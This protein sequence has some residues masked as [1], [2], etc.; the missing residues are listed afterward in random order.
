[1]QAERTGVALDYVGLARLVLRV[2]GAVVVLGSVG[3][4]AAVG[5]YGVPNPTVI[6]AS[7]FLVLN[8]VMTSGCVDGR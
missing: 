2:Y 6:G 1:V 8:P 7:Y 4:L 3:H 5:I